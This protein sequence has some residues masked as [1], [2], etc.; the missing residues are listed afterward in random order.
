M[1][2]VPHVLIIAGIL[3]S[4]SVMSKTWTSLCGESTHCGIVGSLMIYISGLW[5]YVTPNYL[6]LSPMPLTPHP[7]ICSR[8][9][10]SVCVVYSLICH[11][12]LNSC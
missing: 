11:S 7:T 1:N 12:V 6:T 9:L 4:I 10:L 3:S 5:K 8:R 2:V